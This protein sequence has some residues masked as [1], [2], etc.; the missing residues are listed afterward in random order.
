MLPVTMEVLKWH[1]VLCVVAIRS[2]VL[3]VDHPSILCEWL[4][5]CFRRL[6]LQCCGRVA[7]SFHQPE[8][9]DFAQGMTLDGV[10]AGSLCIFAGHVV[11]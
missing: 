4:R 7:Q 2:F 11:A 8:V 9:R 5:D 10:L 6:S 1:A 3:G